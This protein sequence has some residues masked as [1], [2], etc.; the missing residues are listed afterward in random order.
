MF[1]IFYNR[2]KC[3]GCG[4]CAEEAPNRWRMNQS[5]GKSNLV[6]GRETKGLFVAQVHYEELTENE[7]ARDN[8]PANVIRLEVP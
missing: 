6:N 7:K 8:C 1:K 4:V 5:D 3:I 2:R